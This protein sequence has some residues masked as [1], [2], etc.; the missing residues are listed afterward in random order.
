MSSAG[1]RI[2]WS[3]LSQGMA[4]K[5]VA[6]GCSKDF[7]VSWVERGR[8]ITVGVKPVQPAWSGTGDQVNQFNQLFWNWRPGNWLNEFWEVI[9]VFPIEKC[10]VLFGLFLYFLHLYKMNYGCKLR[11]EVYLDS[12]PWKHRFIQMIDRTLDVVF[13]RFLCVTFTIFLRQQFKGVVC[14]LRR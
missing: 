12:I 10:Y 4:F 7:G 6:L 9:T 8:I 2:F 1:S 11:I 14:S 13:S 3:I 5:S